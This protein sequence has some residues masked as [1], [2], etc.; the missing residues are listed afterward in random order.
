MV[1]G[2]RDHRARLSRNHPRRQ[3]QQM[4][5]HDDGTENGREDVTEDVLERVAVESD[6]AEGGGPLVVRLVDGLV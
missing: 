3:G 2:V 1:P 5:T 6:D 4:R